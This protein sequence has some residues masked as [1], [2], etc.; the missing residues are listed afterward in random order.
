MTVATLL[1]TCLVFLL[2]GWTGNAYYVTAL[3]VGAVVCIAASNGGTTSQDLKTGWIVGGTPKYQ[4]IA[5]L[6]GA[7]ASALALGPILLK[8]NDTGTV[9][10]PQHMAAKFEAKE[11]QPTKVEPL[12]AA[13]LPK[14]KGDDAPSG[15]WNVLTADGKG[16]LTAGDYLV[17]QDGTIAYTIQTTFKEGLKP[18][19]AALSETKEGLTGSQATADA[20]TYRSWHKAESDESGPAGKY[21]I[22]DAGAPK[23]YVDP[24]INGTHETRPD[25]SSA[26]K[27]SAPKA[28]LMSYI[29]KGILN[30]SLPWALVLLGVMLAIMFEMAGIPSLAF[31]VG[32]YLP[33]SSST[34]IMIGGLVRGLVDWRH[35]KSLVAKGLTEEEIT[36]EGDK[37]PGVLL[38]SGY[39]AG[40]AIAG[41]L[42]AFA[43]GVM[44]DSLD[45]IHEWATTKNPA[46]MGEHADLISFLPFVAL[47]TLLFLVG[48]RRKATPAKAA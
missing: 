31:A 9:Y 34:P 23:Y 11:G 20:A 16:K 29:I 2:I 4:Q 17:G 26:Q 33:L 12:E 8:L 6:V 1:L 3:S 42:I 10:V 18:E 36:A 13:S 37:S 35:R 43:A 5:I 39:I 19:T 47:A 40:G 45:K 27:F 28:T 21:L 15:D 14:Y 22:D 30:G 44:K 38:A 7:S 32:V 24:G 48:A 41:I 46:V 25:G